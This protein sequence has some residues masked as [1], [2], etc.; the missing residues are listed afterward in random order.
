MDQ[1]R[2]SIKDLQVLLICMMYH[3]DVN[4]F[5]GYVLYDRLATKPRPIRLKNRKDFQQFYL[6]VRVFRQNLIIS[7]KFERQKEFTKATYLYEMG[8]T[9]KTKDERVKRYLKALPQDNQRLGNKRKKNQSPITLT[10]KKKL[11]E[12]YN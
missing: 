10:D 4:F 3:Y 9:T 2:I 5:E 1:A 8:I 11:L 12:P 6:I 7:E